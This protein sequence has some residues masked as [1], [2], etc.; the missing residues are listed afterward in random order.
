VSK[1]HYV[2]IFTD[3]RAENVKDTYDWYDILIQV[4]THLESAGSQTALAHMLLRDGKIII[5]KNLGQM[6]Y[7]FLTKKRNAM[8][9]AADSVRQSFLEPMPA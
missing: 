3:G 8:N 4:G 2:I 9:T 5:E 1:H 7:D 6:G